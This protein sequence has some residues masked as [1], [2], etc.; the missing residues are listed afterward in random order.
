LKA[1]LNEEVK[2]CA[3]CSLIV[4]NQKRIFLDR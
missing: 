1:I 2:R 4:N 3:A